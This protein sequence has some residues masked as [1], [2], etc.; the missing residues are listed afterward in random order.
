M[1]VQHQHKETASA[2][3]AAPRQDIGA[4]LPQRANLDLL[5]HK[6]KPISRYSGSWEWNIVERCD[7]QSILKVVETLY[8]YELRKGAWLTDIGLWKTLF[9][10]TVVE[11]VYELARTG[12]ISLLPEAEPM[13]GRRAS[14]GKES[15]RA[16][17]WNE[18]GD[19]AHLGQGTR[20]PLNEELRRQSKWR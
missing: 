12:Y 3:D 11:T 9:D 5:V 18:N 1:A 20:R 4:G 6:L 15:M 14:N 16:D 13:E 7:G 10:R 8:L 17:E 2:V 19:A